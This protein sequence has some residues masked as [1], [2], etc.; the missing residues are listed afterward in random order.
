V[1]HYIEKISI[2]KEKRT[3]LPAMGIRPEK[4]IGETAIK[5]FVEFI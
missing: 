5:I 3:P 4:T 2:L 1:T